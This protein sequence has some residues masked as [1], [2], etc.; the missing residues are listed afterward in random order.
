MSES[1]THTLEASYFRLLKYKWCMRNAVR[2]VSNMIAKSK[3][4]K[5]R[6]AWESMIGSKTKMPTH[7]NVD[8]VLTINDNVRHWMSLLHPKRWISADFRWVS[9]FHCRNV[10]VCVSEWVKQSVDLNFGR[11]KVGNGLV[12]HIHQTKLVHKNWILWFEASFCIRRYL[13]CSM[14]YQSVFF[15]FCFVIHAS[16]PNSL[17]IVKNSGKNGSAYSSSFF[18]FVSSSSPFPLKRPFFRKFCG[19]EN[20]IVYIWCRLVP[21][22]L[23]RSNSFGWRVWDQIRNDGSHRIETLRKFSQHIDSPNWNVWCTGIIESKKKK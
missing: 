10:R 18:R 9:L 22:F 16:I 12:M 13:F 23:F 4:W 20:G 19:N 14:F 7:I 15:V 21:C 11:Q 6:C 8:C 1:V 17:R 2:Y 3:W 5:W